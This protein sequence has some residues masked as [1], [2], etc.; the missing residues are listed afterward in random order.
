MEEVVTT[1]AGRGHTN[2]IVIAW[3]SV[4]EEV[5][6]EAEKGHTSSIAMAWTSV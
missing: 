3:T 2:S 5:T 1:E 4:E 6:M